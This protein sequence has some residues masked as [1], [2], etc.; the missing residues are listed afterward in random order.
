M[1]LRWKQIQTVRRHPLVRW[2]LFGV[3]TYLVLLVLLALLENSLVYP[4]W[5]ILPGDWEPRGLEFEDVHFA[6][7]DGVKLHGWYFDH[8]EPRA[9]VVYCH[10]NGIDVSHLGMEMRALSRMQDI[11]IFAF[12]YRGYGRSEGRPSEAG[13]YRDAAAAQQWLAQRAGLAPED[14]VLMGRSLGGAV[15]VDTA[16]AHGARALILERTFPSVPDVAAGIYWW[17]PVRW[18]MRNRFEAV[19]KIPQYKGP[20]LQSHGTA[21]TIVP[22]AQ[23]KRL[24][25]AAGSSHKRFVVLHNTEHNDPD[26]DEY[27]GA[28]YEFLSSLPPV[29][30]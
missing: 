16:V 1:M 18:I 27:W 7:S 25:E 26:P 2:P 8:P 5:A 13:L 10:G 30:E 14:V 20:L 29:S 12:D 6:A 3:I 11:A 15:A 4:R 24:F 17:L 21:D 19:K 28:L 22:F 23:G 9:H